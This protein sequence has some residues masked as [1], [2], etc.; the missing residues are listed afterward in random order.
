MSRNTSNTQRSDEFLTG[1]Q[2]WVDEA[3]EG[4]RISRAEAMMRIVEA[5]ENSPGWLSLKSL[6]LSS[7]PKEIWNL[8]DLKILHLNN[9]QL[10]TLPAGIGNLTDLKHLYLN[11]NQLTAISEQ[12]GNLTALESLYL[13]GNKLNSIPYSIIETRAARSLIILEE[14]LI[15]AD[16]VLRLKTLA[17]QNNVVL[18]IRNQLSAAGQQATTNEIFSRASFEEEKEPQTSMSR[19][20]N[21]A[22]RPDE[23]LAGLQAWV[24]EAPEGERDSRIDAMRRIVAVNNSGGDSLSLE[25]LELSSLPKE[26][27]NLTALKVLNLAG[28]ELNTI[29]AEI[30]NL[31]AL[32]VLDLFA[33][34]LNTIPPQIGGLTALRELR[35]EANQL[36]TVPPQIENL[37][38]LTYLDLSGNQ[39]NTIPAEIGGLIALEVLCLY[40]NQLNTIPPQIGG[41]TALRELNLA[42]NQLNTIPPQ[43]GNLPALEVLYLFSNQLTTIPEYLLT[44][45]VPEEGFTIDLRGN[46]IELDEANRLGL[47]ARNHDVTLDFD[48][49]LDSDTRL[50]LGVPPDAERQDTI[51]AITDE[52]LSR[53]SFGVEREELRS[54]LESTSS[55]FQMFLAECPRTQGWRSRREEMTGCLF[56]IVKKMN[57][58]EAVKTKC[59][60]LAETA[61]GTCGDRVALAFVQMQLSLNLPNKKLEEMSVREVYDYAKQESVIKFLSEKSEAKVEHLKDEGIRC[62]EIETHL[63]YLQIGPDLGLDLKANGMLYQRCS[64]VTPAELEATKAEFLALDRERL[65]AEH[66]YED[67]QLRLHP[68]VQGIIADVADK[69]GGFGEEKKG[70]SDEKY[71]RRMNTLQALVARTAISRIQ[72]VIAAETRSAGEQS[73]PEGFVDRLRSTVAAT[74]APSGSIASS[75]ATGPLAEA[76]TRGTGRS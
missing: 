58:S 21:N 12:I 57:Q 59:E 19:N 23:F 35:L 9:N 49:F 7:L 55:N 75:D 62:D 31:T 41:L 73:A 68:V 65:I 48:M 74:A 69:V 45:E 54:F 50:Y 11:N 33:N 1:L 2:A 67:G 38:A 51:S 27:W 6:G 10:S 26:I 30:G 61:F 20:T 56:E 5:K 28:N 60:S 72:E 3:P 14:N 44:R 66:I 63:A 53:A 76:T 16:E 36:N 13:E 42:G 70:E 64:H 71:V 24:D 17:N 22:Q 8:T 15:S 43:I 52:I 18:G 32:E 25:D 46:P 47:L 4:E 34:E 40:D 29:P 37:T 39:L